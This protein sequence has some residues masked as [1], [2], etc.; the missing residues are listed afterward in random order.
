MKNF[1]LIVLV[2]FSMINNMSAQLFA[3]K[4]TVAKTP[5]NTLYRLR[6]ED[7][8]LTTGYFP[9][10]EN[11]VVFSD[12]NENLTYTKAGND[13]VFKSLAFMDACYVVGQKGDFVELIKY[14][15]KLLK[16]PL[17][18]KIDAKSA[19][20]L[21]WINKNNLLLWRGT[22]KD[23]LSLFSTK[24]IAVFKNENIIQSYS[25]NIVSDSLL[26]FSS[27]LT[28]T[29]HMKQALRDLLFV[30]KQSDDGKRWLVGKMAHFTVDNCKQNMIGWIDADYIKLWGNRSFLATLKNDTT[31]EGELFFTDTALSALSF[32]L[33]GNNCNKK[34]IDELYPLERVIKHDSADSYV[35][36]MV[37]TD[38]FDY[39]RN[40]AINVLGN[41]ISYDECRKTIRTQDNL[42]IV[43][44]VDGGKTNGK[45]VGGL[46]N[47][48]QSLNAN[49]RSASGFK[50]IR[51]GAVLYKD[52]LV[53]C[54]DVTNVFP[55]HED[56]DELAV[57]FQKQ[58][59]EINKCNNDTVAQAMFAGIMQGAKLLDKHENESNIIVLIGAAGNNVNEG[60]SWSDVVRSVNRVDARILVFQTHNVSHPS[61][62]DFVIQGKDLVM[63]VSANNAE[64]KKEKLIDSRQ[65]LA[66]NDFS[67]LTGDSGV[68]YLDYPARS[69]E[70]G[71]VIFPG[72]N[73]VMSPYL[74][75]K[76]IDSL[77]GSIQR[78]NQAIRNSYR[79]FF[80][81][82]G[83]RNTAV[84]NGYEKYFPSYADRHLPITFLQSVPLESPLFCVPARLHS[85]ENDPL[86]NG[87]QPGL[88]LTGDEYLQVQ[89]VFEKLG[90]LFDQRRPGRRFIYRNICKQLKEVLRRRG[91]KDVAS[92]KRLSFATA[93]DLMTGYKTNNDLWQA[94]QLYMIKKKHKMTTEEILQILRTFKEK[95]LWMKE[96]MGD[97]TYSFMSNGQIYYALIAEQ[98]F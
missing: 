83:I 69:M 40:F 10:K 16:T 9:E 3:K 63:S 61:F 18:H 23:R 67:L 77:V 90:K 37:L 88:L 15:P 11:W 80:R 43:F 20:Y 73:R 62:N 14:D 92:Y 36:T 5:A 82:V 54:R 66:Q 91:M 96:N 86:L 51:Y 84:A 39:S 57:F 76:N 4:M 53:S 22:L 81:T 42:N 46:L 25:S 72:K 95:S 87:F 89:N 2:Y 55:L 93:T 24:A 34:V 79:Q 1:S 60:T 94:K 33:G 98:L 59:T 45:Y 97:K 50:N 13:I 71:Y 78:D 7:L 17:N 65:V 27:P 32:P 68:Y 85:S 38:I 48:L 47:T 30:Y 19:D 49:L 6:G 44:V 41:K 12:R 29:Q 56:I 8:L 35:K 28:N 52:N 31:R 74:L 26:S 70:P 64:L 58:L 21:G 75:E